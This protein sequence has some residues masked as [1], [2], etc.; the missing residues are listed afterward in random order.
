MKLPLYFPLQ[1][2]P[3]C[4]SSYQLNLATEL[5]PNKVKEWR[6]QPFAQLV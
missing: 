6:Q 3:P 4:P 1:L 2:L 5:I